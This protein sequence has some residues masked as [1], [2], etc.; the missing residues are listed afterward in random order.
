MTASRLIVFHEAREVGTLQAHEEGAMRFSYATSWL[1][2]PDAF[3][4]SVRM[5]LRSGEYEREAAAFFPNLLP[6][7]NVRLRLA[8]R[9]GLSVENDF[10]L[11]AAVGGECAGALTLMPEGQ[12][13]VEQGTSYRE[14]SPRDLLKLADGGGALPV[15]GGSEGLR[16]S[17]AGAQDKVPVRM[18]GDRIFLPEGNAPSTHILK[19]ES[20]Y[21]KHLPANEV[22]TLMLA[23]AVRVPAVQG[24]LLAVGRR[25]IFLVERYDR[26]EGN[27]LIH[28][29]H[30][31]DLCQALAVPPARK[32]EREGGPAFADCFQVVADAS[33]EPARDARALLRWLVFNVLALNAD[34]HAKN[35]SLLYGE[36]G[37]VLAP[38]YDLI[39]TRAYPSL[40]RSL[41]MSIAGEWD[42]TLLLRRHW[43]RLAERLGVGRRYVIELVSEMADGMPE[44]LSAT[45]KAFRE[46]HGDSPALQLTVP[47][48]RAQARRLRRRLE[49]A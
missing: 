28:R 7:G 33:L 18:D 43:E 40:A 48:I 14:I 17:L 35:L 11:L 27:G 12:S 15:L 45:S 1:S 37:C 24:T 19:F 32:Y 39:C 4:I 42:P 23:Q 8:R 36:G 47:K 26:R 3:P 10:E 38:A 9:L 41:A 44:A 34:G 6:E 31:E 29:L 22:F 5:P 25:R 2:S 46:R 49:E 20:P 16:L 13:P 30:Q 21:F